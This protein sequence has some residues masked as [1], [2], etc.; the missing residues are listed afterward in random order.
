MT[1][2]PDFDDHLSFNLFV[3]VSLCFF[4][5]PC[6]GSTR[7]FDGTSRSGNTTTCYPNPALN[8]PV[9]PVE[10]VHNERL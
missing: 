4:K 7:A 8:K 2:K 9:E 1:F 6:L 3:Y 10:P 5:T